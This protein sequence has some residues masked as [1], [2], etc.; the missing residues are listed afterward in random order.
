MVCEKALRFWDTIFEFCEDVYDRRWPRKYNSS[1]DKN[2]YNIGVINGIF[3]SE[4]SN[5][6]FIQFISHT[7][8]A[9]YFSVPGNWKFVNSKLLKIRARYINCCNS[10]RKKSVS[11]G[12]KNLSSKRYSTPLL[13]KYYRTLEFRNT[14]LKTRIYVGADRLY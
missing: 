12:G 10:W 6:Y 1:A 4:I 8:L 5:I 14:F 3:W 11:M 13:R 7:S 2:L 9:K